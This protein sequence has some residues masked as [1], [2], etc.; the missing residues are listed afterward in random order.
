MSVT[1]CG[2][3]MFHSDV[4]VKPEASAFPSPVGAPHKQ[5]R[6]AFGEYPPLDLNQDLAV[7]TVVTEGEAQSVPAASSGPPVAPE[8]R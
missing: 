5:E 4:A 8:E 6:M 3:W 7:V 1:A 2:E